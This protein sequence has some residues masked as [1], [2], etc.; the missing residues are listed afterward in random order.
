MSSERKRRNKTRDMNKQRQ[1]QP[2]GYLTN[3]IIMIELSD[4]TL[5][6]SLKSRL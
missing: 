2:G 3:I 5:K 4:I 1:N 6:Y